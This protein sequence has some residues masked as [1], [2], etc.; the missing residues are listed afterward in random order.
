MTPEM[1]WTEVDG[2]PTLIGQGRGSRVK[3]GLLFRVGRADETLATSGITHLLEHLALHQQGVADY[4]F[5]GA[6]ADVYTHFHVEGTAEHV[7]EYFVSVCASLRNLPLHRLETEKE[8]LRTEQSGRGAPPQI[9]VYRFGAQ[10]F[11]LSSYQELGLSGL[12]GDQVTDWARR[13]FTRDNAVF[14]VIADALPAGLR[15]DLLGGQRNPPP[16][17]T[18]ELPETPAWFAG[19]VDGVCM[20]ALVPRSTSAMLFARILGKSLFHDLRQRG[21]YSYTAQADYQPLDRDLAIVTAVADSAPDKRGAVIG[22]LLDVLARLRFGG[23]THAE[24]ESAKTVMCHGL[25]ELD[26]EQLVPGH[27]M[28]ALIGSPAPS[29]VEL[30]AEIEAAT[31]EDLHRVGQEVYAS[32]LVQVPVL[33]LDWAG[34]PQAPRWSESAVTGKTYPAI[35]DNAG[36]LV[37]GRDGVSMRVGD[38]AVTV[39]YADCVA[40]QAYPD[41]GRRL[42]GRDGFAVQIEPTLNSVSPH[43]LREVVRAVPSSLVISMPPRRADQIPQP[44]VEPGQVHAPPPRPPMTKPRS[45]LRDLMRKV[46]YVTMWALSAFTLLV[47]VSSTVGTLNGE[48]EVSWSGSIV[49]W[50]FLCILAWLTWKLKRPRHLLDPPS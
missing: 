41:G 14:W 36:D 34:I 46:A 12:T 26:A 38:E 49:C 45:G 17:V 1:H 50:V 47:A 20:Q 44:T 29:P 32:A 9:P 10:G 18:S 19:T 27:A 37:V 15:L 16:M 40:V 4:H 11:G 28:S 5:N 39:R 48:P 13:H 25:E 33:G 21:G 7:V 22:G 3:A 43:V 35:G 8:I 6:T 42:F 2:V 23:I 30:R 31:I 24:L